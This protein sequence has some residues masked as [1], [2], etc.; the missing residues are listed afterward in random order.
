MNVTIEIDTYAGLMN[1][2]PGDELAAILREAARK[3]EGWPGENAF[4]LG[5]RD[6]NGVKVG[7]LM[8]LPDDE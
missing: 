4:S 8:A 2:Q 6:S 1:G 7:D 5:L 3:I